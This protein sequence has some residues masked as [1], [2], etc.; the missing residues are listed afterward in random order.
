MGF[1]ATWAEKQGW[2]SHRTYPHLR[3]HGGDLQ[4][5]ELWSAYG[6]LSLSSK[7]KLF[8]T[9]EDYWRHLGALCCDFLSLI[10][11]IMVTASTSAKRPGGKIW[12]NLNYLTISALQRCTSQGG[13]AKESGESRTK[14]MGLSRFWICSTYA[15]VFRTL[16]RRPSDP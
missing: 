15:V 10:L 9:G 8:R 13:K 3:F 14:V 5:G 7:D 1:A 6:V 4:A 11:H 2:G 16:L 12:G